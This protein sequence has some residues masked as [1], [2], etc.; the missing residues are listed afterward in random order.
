MATNPSLRRFNRV[1]LLLALVTLA[2]YAAALITALMLFRGEVRNQILSRDG[3]LLTS[4]GQHFHDRLS[5]P[6]EEIDLLEV[7]LESSG[8]RG[9]IGVRLY[10]AGGELLGKVPASLYEVGLSEADRQALADATPLSRFYPDFQL[11]T[12]FSDQLDY[13]NPVRSPLVEVLSPLLTAEPDGEVVAIIQYWLDG[14]EVATELQHLNGSLTGV[15]I[16]F[17]SAGTLVFLAVFLIARGRILRMGQLL[18]ERNR[19]LEQANADLALA[20]RTSAIGS[21]T[22]HLFHGLKNPLAGLKTYLRVTAGNEEAFAL[23]NRMQSLIDET[24]AVIRENDAG[25]DFELSFKELFEAAESRYDGS[26]GRKVVVEGSGN[27]SVSARKSRLLFLVLRNL[28]DNAID[29]SPPDG[30]VRITLRMQDNSLQVEVEDTGPGLPAVIRE[31]LFE[32]VTTT[33]QGGTGIG[34]ALSAAIARQIPARLAL[35]HSS[36][37]GTTFSIEMPL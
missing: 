11:D 32:P 26:N 17:M 13:A 31:R 15:G 5:P 23:A 2:I 1:I 24:L 8:I 36:S 3:T 9:V 34:L 28:V 12:L 20:A 25:R 30:K 6:V 33:K 18:E 27:G 19:S 29:A 21:V 37:S 16:V 35:K 7:A 22:S 10:D 14:Q 4:V